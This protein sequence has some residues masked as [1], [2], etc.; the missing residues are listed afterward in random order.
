MIVIYIRAVTVSLA[1]DPGWEVTDA[2][3]HGVSISALDLRF[4]L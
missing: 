4:L 3:E 1:S 2:K